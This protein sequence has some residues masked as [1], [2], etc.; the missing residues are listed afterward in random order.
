MRMDGAPR[1]IRIPVLALRGPRP[2]PLDDGGKERRDFIMPFGGRQR[3]FLPCSGRVIR[4]F[5]TVRGCL[6]DRSITAS[7]KLSDTFLPGLAG[8]DLRALSCYHP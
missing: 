2:G 4:D 1:G 5:R 7:L 8:F 3:R 6:R